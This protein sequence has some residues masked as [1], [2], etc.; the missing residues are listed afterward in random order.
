[1]VSFNQLHGQLLAEGLAGRPHRLQA[2]DVGAAGQ[3]AAFKPGP[4][5][6]C[7]LRLADQRGHPAPHDVV[8]LQGHLGLLR[9]RVAN[10]RG[11]VKRLG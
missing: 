9:Q 11:R 4:V 2:G 10:G 1:M 5:P 3:P 8:D 7:F 6:A